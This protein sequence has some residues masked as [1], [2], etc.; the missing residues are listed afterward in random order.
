MMM[1]LPLPYEA[2]TDQLS[3]DDKIF[4]FFCASGP[5]LCGYGGLDGCN[6]LTKKLKD[7]GFNVVYT[8]LCA[9]GPCNRRLLRQ[10][11]QNPKCD[12]ADTVIISGCDGF[13]HNAKAVFTGKKI[14][15]AFT[16][17]YGNM[18]VNMAT[19][20]ITLVN[21][22]MPALQE[23]GIDDFPAEGG[24]PFE[25]ITEAYL[26]KYKIEKYPPW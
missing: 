22:Y 2:I 11:A 13:L 24:L 15:K 4:V 8:N 16:N 18:N 1:S 19:F 6:R 20:K 14:V 23:L 10:V 7:D 9:G 21:P 26:Q 3:K 5:F 17:T 12:Q 25:K